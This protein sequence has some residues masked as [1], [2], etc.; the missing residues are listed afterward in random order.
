MPGFNRRSDWHD[1]FDQVFDSHYQAQL[2]SGLDV[3][4]FRWPE[5]FPL[6]QFEAVRT[7]SKPPQNPNE[8]DWGAWD[9]PDR[10][11]GDG[12]MVEW[13]VK[14]LA[15]P[16]LDLGADPLGHKH[17]EERRVAQRQPFHRAAAVFAYRPGPRARW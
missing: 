5:G 13:A 7:F 12:R 9:K 11:M 1:Y 3:K 8:F 15:Q 10:E 4:Q 6:N 14:F 2:A 16:W 17:H